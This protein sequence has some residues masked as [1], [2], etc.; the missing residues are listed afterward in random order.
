MALKQV[1]E[2]YELLDSPKANGE[3]VAS[4]LKQRGIHDVEVVPIQKEKKERPIQSRSG[5]RDQRGKNPEGMHPL[6]VSLGDWEEWGQ[7]PK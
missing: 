7:G 2:I 1:I 3:K 5:F 6:S 4:V